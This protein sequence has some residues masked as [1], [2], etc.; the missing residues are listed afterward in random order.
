M[1]KA[2]GIGAAVLVG[3]VLVLAA[4]RPD[5]LEQQGDATRVTSSSTWIA[6]SARNS[7]PASRA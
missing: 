6:W 5:T 7:K 2:I 1:L 4:F 3:G